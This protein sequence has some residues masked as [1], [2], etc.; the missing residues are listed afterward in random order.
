MK[1]RTALA[2][3]GEGRERRL[4]RSRGRGDA[5]RLRLLADAALAIGVAG[6]IVEIVRILTDAARSACG[7]RIAI[8]RLSRVGP[9][10]RADGMRSI[11][12]EPAGSANRRILPSGLERLVAERNLPIRVHQRALGSLGDHGRASPARVTHCMA[13]QLVG[14]DRRNLGVLQLANGPDREFTVHDERMLVPLAQVAAETIEGRRL[15]ADVAQSRHQVAQLER[16]MVCLQ[17]EERRAIACELHDEVGQTL[18]GLKLMLEAAAR[19]GGSMDFTQAVDSV[20][21]M[22]E[23]V[24]DLSLDLRPPMLDDLGLVPT[25]L[26]HFE[27]YEGQTGIRVGFHHRGVTGRFRGGLEITMFRIVQESLTNV[28]RHAGT[29]EVTV[30]L[31]RGANELHVRIEDRGC[32]FDSAGGAAPVTFGLSG[33]RERAVLS[34]GICVVVSG[35]GQGTR[36]MARVPVDA[37]ASG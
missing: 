22:L 15:W 30:E 28:A 9:G 20:G 17:E 19:P 1:A 6:S 4:A 23:R 14:R 27:R 10:R 12:P 13:I 31:W 18:T 21:H 33:M 35:P 7:A 25:L 8:T 24:R 3:E 32:G 34:G 16:R 36:V 2:I 29:S 11:S 5:G 37:K 26:W